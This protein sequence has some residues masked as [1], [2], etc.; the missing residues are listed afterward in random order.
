MLQAVQRVFFGASR[1][2][3]RPG[4]H[5]HGD[6]PGQSGERL[7]IRWH[8]VAALAPLALFVVWIGLVPGTFLTPVSAAVRGATDAAAAA[9]AA[10]MEAPAAAA[11][12]V[13][14]PDLAHPV[15]RTP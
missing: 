2:P 10:R 4:S 15:T 8:E 5:G 12:V 3:P 9:F 11:D 7:D 1:E 13:G 6:G 14:G